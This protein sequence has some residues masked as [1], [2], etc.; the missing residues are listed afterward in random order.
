MYMPT[1]TKSEVNTRTDAEIAREVTRRM[2]EDI[3][4]PDDR[5]TTKVAEGSITIAGT[6][7]RDAQKVAAERCAREVRGMR[8]ITNKIEVDPTAAPFEG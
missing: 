6:V 1:R 7:N 2:K 8:G 5:I 3:E 4:V